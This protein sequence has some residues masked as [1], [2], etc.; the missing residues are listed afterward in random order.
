MLEVSNQR[1]CQDCG[2][3]LPE[4]SKSSIISQES[5]YSADD[6]SFQQI[7]QKPIKMSSPRPLSKRSLAFGIVSLVIAMTS[8][9]FGSSLIMEPTIFSFFSSRNLFIALGAVNSVGLVFGIVSI[10]LNK[11]ARNLESINKAMK[12]GRTLGTLG[13]TLNIILTIVAFSFALISV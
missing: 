3:K 7:Q 10:Y 6:R 2:A 4:F 9:N 13:L 12:A 5:S 8:F 11:K 1:F